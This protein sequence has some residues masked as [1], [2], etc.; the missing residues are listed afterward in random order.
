MKKHRGELTPE[1]VEKTKNSTSELEVDLTCTCGARV[2]AIRGM[3]GHY[4]PYHHTIAGT[5]KHDTS[6]KRINPK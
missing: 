2:T 5:D 4:F 3:N 1:S 6:T